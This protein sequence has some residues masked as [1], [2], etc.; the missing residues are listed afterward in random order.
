MG[1]V[2]YLLTSSSK[3]QLQRVVVH[4]FCLCTIVAAL[5]A[6]ENIGWVFLMTFNTFDRQ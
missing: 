3:S 1:T 5:Y 2:E 6:F 4:F